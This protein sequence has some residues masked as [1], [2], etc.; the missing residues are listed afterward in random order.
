M[1]SVRSRC[2]AIVATAMLVVL[3][4]VPLG[5]AQQASLGAQPTDGA[6]LVQVKCRRCHPI[7]RVQAAHK[8]RAGWTATV[9]RMTTHG[10][11]VTSGQKAAIVDYL[12]TQDGQ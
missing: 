10:L 1:G 3:A 12:S 9:E 6:G 5:C 7:E 2:G 4:T 8:N 11:E